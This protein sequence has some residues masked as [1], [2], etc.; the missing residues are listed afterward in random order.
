MASFCAKKGS[1]GR[2]RIIIEIVEIF[3][4]IWGVNREIRKN[5]RRIKVYFFK[6]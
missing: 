5:S 6:R 3:S 4:T 2:I 1:F